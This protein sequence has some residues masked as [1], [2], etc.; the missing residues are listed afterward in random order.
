VVTSSRRGISRLILLIV[1]AAVLTTFSAAPASAFG[2][3]CGGGCLDTTPSDS[4]APG[5]IW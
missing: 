4:T 1:L 2:V 3:G 5:G